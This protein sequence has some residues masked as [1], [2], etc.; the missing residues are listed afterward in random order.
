MILF[1][2][3]DSFSHTGG[4]Q[5]VARTLS[6]TLG[7]LSKAANRKITY[8]N[9]SLYDD[10]P[11]NRYIAPSQFKGF[12]GNVFCFILQT[13]IK[14]VCCK[15]IVVNHINLLPLA[16]LIKIVNYRLQIILI[17]HG[18]EVWREQTFLKNAC[19]QSRIQIWAV[20]NYT[21]NLLKTQHRIKA[22]RIF[23]LH[24]CIDPFFEIPKAFNKPGYLLKKYGLSAD[25]PILLTISRLNRYENQKGYDKIIQLLP[26]LMKQFPNLHYLL[27][28]KSDQ[29]EVLRLKKLITERKLGKH[30]TLVGFIPESVL[31]NHYL[32]ADVFVL[33]SQKEGFGL[34]FIEAAHCGCQIISG[35]CDGSYEA[36]LYGALGTTVDPN[37]I[38]AIKNALI[39][40][41]SEQGFPAQRSGKQDPAIQ[42]LK[43]QN[44]AIQNFSYTQYRRKIAA[45]LAIK[46]TRHD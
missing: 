18:T 10:Q 1:L 9:F 27:C 31:S 45:L 20:S 7:K 39:K 32:L 6:Y 8:Y 35:N 44:T 28:G 43:I 19:L 12:K 13:I 11:D 5:K 26:E 33:P 30:I 17:A 15:T 16:C 34:V 23:V 37:N 40:N 25:Q 3:L 21:K 41:L 14:G 46:T 24:N 29:Q 4:I 38:N 22:K 36:M 2:T 42:K